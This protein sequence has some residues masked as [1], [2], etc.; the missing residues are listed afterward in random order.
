MRRIFYSLLIPLGVACT[1]VEPYGDDTPAAYSPGDGTT[2]KNDDAGAPPRKSLPVASHDAGVWTSD[3]QPPPVAPPLP[4][5][6]PTPA[7]SPTP[8]PVT[9]DGGTGPNQ[10]ADSGATTASLAA[11]CA[12]A[13]NAFRGQNDLD[14]YTVSPTLA[15]FAAQAVA[16]DA[17]SGQID[18][19][20]DGNGG[21]GVS[22]AEDELIGRDVDPG[23][24][25]EQVLE[26]GLLDEE[27]GEINGNGNLFSQRFSQV[28]C[29]V[30]QSQDGQYWIAIEYQ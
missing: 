17:T 21:D 10:A 22:R 8:A 7:P 3:A 2:T 15:A 28:G 18:G 9:D 1:A 16:S 29:G 4:I 23:G 25:A 11:W 27:N 26:L 14:P 30:A 13:I 24:T 5:S 20:F 6:T 12:G 19:Y